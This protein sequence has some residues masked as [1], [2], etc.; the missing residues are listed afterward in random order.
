MSITSSIA[1]S[2]INSKQI[3]KDSQQRLDD[4]AISALNFKTVKGNQ[5]GLLTTVNEMKGTFYEANDEFYNIVSQYIFLDLNL[6]YSAIIQE[7]R[8][9]EK[10]DI[11]ETY[12]NDYYNERFMSCLMNYYKHSPAFFKTLFP[13]QLQ[14]INKRNI[15]QS[16]QKYYYLLCIIQFV[17]DNYM[18]DR[19]TSLPLKSYNNIVNW[20][21]T[22]ND[23]NIIYQLNGPNKNQVITFDFAKHYHSLI[24]VQ[25]TTQDINDYNKLVRLQNLDNGL[26]QLFEFFKMMPN[27]YNKNPNFANQYVLHINTYDIKDKSVDVDGKLVFDLANIDFGDTTNDTTRAYIDEI[28]KLQTKDI[29]L[30]KLNIKKL[31]K[32]FNMYNRLK[33]ESLIVDKRTY[34]NDLSRYNVV[35]LV[36]EGIQCSDRTVGSNRY[37]ANGD[38]AIP[39]KFSVNDNGDYEFKTLTEYTTYRPER[40]RVKKCQIYLTLDNNNIIKPY[41]INLDIAKDDLYNIP[42][43]IVDYNPHN[44]DFNRVNKNKQFPDIIYNNDNTFDAKNDKIYEEYISSNDIKKTYNGCY[45]MPSYNMTADSINLTN[46][47]Y[48]YDDDTKLIN[49]ITTNKLTE[50]MLY[51]FFMNEQRMLGVGYCLDI[52]LN[53]YKPLTSY[54][55]LLNKFRSNSKG[56]IQIEDYIN[57]HEPMIS[58]SPYYAYKNHELTY[59]LTKHIDVFKNVYYTSPRGDIFDI[60]LTFENNIKTNVFVPSS[61]MIKMPLIPIPFALYRQYDPKYSTITGD[62]KIVYNIT[63]SNWGYFDTYNITVNNTDT[64]SGITPYDFIILTNLSSDERYLLFYKKGTVLTFEFTL[65]GNNELTID[66]AVVSTSPELLDN[67]DPNIPKYVKR[68]NI[69]IPISKTLITTDTDYIYFNNGETIYNKNYNGDYNTDKNQLYRNYIVSDNIIYNP[70]KCDN[71]YVKTFNEETLYNNISMIT[72]LDNDIKDNEI[73]NIIPNG[74]TSDPFE[75]ELSNCYTSTSLTGEKHYIKSSNMLFYPTA[76]NIVIDDINTTEL[77]LWRCNQYMF[78]NFETSYNEQNAVFAELVLHKSNIQFDDNFIKDAQILTTDN[79]LATEEQTKKYFELLASYL[80][81]YMF[82]ELFLPTEDTVAHIPNHMFNLSDDNKTP[83]Y[84]KNKN[85]VIIYRFNAGMFLVD[86]INYYSSYMTI[87][88]IK[89]KPIILK[90]LYEYKYEDTNYKHSIM[91]FY[92][93]EYNLVHCFANNTYIVGD[94]FTDKYVPFVIPTIKIILRTSFSKLDSATIYLPIGI[95]T[96]ILPTCHKFKITP[97]DTNLT[98]ILNETFIYNVVPDNLY[99]NTDFSNGDCFKTDINVNEDDYYKRFIYLYKHINTNKK[100]IIYETNKDL[101]NYD[102]V[103]FNNNNNSFYIERYHNKFYILINNTDTTNIENMYSSVL[104]NKNDMFMTLSWS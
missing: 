5:G 59:T 77:Y 51:R 9:L 41:E 1:S 12:I 2:S 26:N 17:N 73:L 14:N 43:K 68:E 64:Y 37:V 100:Y 53:I 58:Y 36:F 28:D 79:I 86:N 90:Q 83:I 56:N 97:S 63:S 31:E 30:S 21:K 15:H 7:A 75:V 29:T 20:C 93:N 89:I 49:V 52:D 104:L 10:N 99:F 80:Q 65:S 67:Y 19:M 4:E 13:N 69:I 95:Q 91:M 85:F 23:P 34:I 25:D 8:V 84:V 35:Y 101:S 47:A 54:D 3:I 44:E 62:I 78:S 46:I 11:F 88:I 102:N 71:F 32:I 72:I 92:N 24:S 45:L 70:L 55:D 16:F 61:A 81:A 38:L 48:L 50:D 66:K 60:T 42:L 103:V 39:G 87:K 6:I 33:V 74:S 27:V 57:V 40:T 94:I 98:Y 96:M 82:T 22:R 76:N 18:D